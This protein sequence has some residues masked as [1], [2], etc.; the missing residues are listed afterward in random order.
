MRS[1]IVADIHSNLEAFRSVVDDAEN[2]GG[3][4]DIW[5]VGDVVGYGPD[6]AA[7]IDL[8]RQYD[9]RRVVGNHDL[10]AIGKLSLEAFNVYGAAAARW[11]T[12]QLT[13]D[14]VSYLRETPFSFELEDFTVVH[15]SP[16]D[17]IWEYLVSSSIAKA[18]F[19]H[20]KTSRCL[21][22]HS[23]LPFICRPQGDNA[24]FLAFPLDR[25]V[26]LGNDRVII[27]PGGVG[28]PRDGDPRASYAIYDWGEGLIWHHRAEYDIPTTQ[29]KMSERGL[30]RYLADRLSHGR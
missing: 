29:R 10:A 4:D 27:N 12:A 2:R 24:V 6:P 21:V 8:L 28:Q 11:T 16:R 15:G 3:F 7:C 26:A 19:R 20:F 30:P 13:E 25:P 14:H 1:L 23:H 5:S 9:H 22:G 18:N 17:P